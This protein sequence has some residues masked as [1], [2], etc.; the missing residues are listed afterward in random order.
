MEF[1]VDGNGKFYK[2]AKKIKS[3][4]E[5]VD[6]IDKVEGLIDDN[7]YDIWFRG[8][9]KQSHKLVPLLY[10]NKRKHSPEMEYE[11]VT[12]F[13]HKGRA[14]LNG[15]KEHDNMWDWLITCQHYGMATRLLDWTTSALVALYFA[16][17]NEEF[18]SSPCVWVLN[19]YA[20]NG[21]SCGEKLVYYTDSVTK[22]DEDN[23]IIKTYSV[24]STELPTNPVAIVP[25]YIDRRLKSQKGCFTLHGRN[26][27]AIHELN[28]KAKSPFLARIEISKFAIDKIRSQL[29]VMGINTSDIYPD[30]TGLAKTINWKNT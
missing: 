7:Y 28:K 2:T 8:A 1:K 12:D 29:N 23:V 11:D 19:P 22:N 21:A 6:A 4:S 14:F 3:L 13:I 17:E 27:Y 5:F 10:R 9:S 20:F 30:L 15:S 18:A 16:I 26:K 24:G 25:P